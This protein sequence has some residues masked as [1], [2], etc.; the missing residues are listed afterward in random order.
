MRRTPA[1]TLNFR[2][3]GG[4]RT[5]D[6]RRTAH[7][8]LFRSDALERLDDA[9]VALLRDELAIAS[10]IDLRAT[11]ETGGAPPPWAAATAIEFASLPMSDDWMEWGE[12]D[13][14]GRRTLLARKYMSFLDAAGANIVAALGI[15]AANAG[16]RP[17]LFHCAVGKD[18]T[19]VLAA[20][21]LTLL[22]V[23]RAEIVADYAVTAAAMPSIIERL[24]ADEL[25][26]HRLE[27][28]PT[29]VYQAEAHTM[30]LFLSLLDER[31]GGAERWARANGLPAA[32]LARL[33]GGLLADAEAVA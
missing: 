6:G 4:L 22:D 25:Y 18:R 9:D 27:V 3:L 5:A 12:L 17:T 23:E 29:E 14:E 31:H 2:D 28:N 32:D 15:V 11:V 20:L 33:R 10:V 19:G 26:R 1:G 8:R 13:E 21:V 16:E 7:G 30:E 24:A